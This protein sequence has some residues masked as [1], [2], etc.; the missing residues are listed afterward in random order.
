MTLNYA[1]YRPAAVESGFAHYAV[2]KDLIQ[3]CIV[4]DFTTKFQDAKGMKKVR[5]M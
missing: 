4:L 1:R 2:L 3:G 5:L